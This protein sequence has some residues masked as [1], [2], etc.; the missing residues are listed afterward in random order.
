LP[1]GLGAVLQ[2]DPDR[3]VDSSSIEGVVGLNMPELVVIDANALATWLA[4]EAANVW[5][6]VDGET[7]LEGQLDLPCTGSDLAI[8]VRKH[9]G[10]L[11]VLVPIMARLAPACAILAHSPCGTRMERVSSSSRGNRNRTIA[12]WSPRMS[13]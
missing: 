6:T 5:W 11:V 12:G 2:V 10:E 3:L 8:A 9:G 4:L 1:R 13:T 7:T